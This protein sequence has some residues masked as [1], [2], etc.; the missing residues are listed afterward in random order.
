M[1]TPLHLLFDVQGDVALELGGDLVVRPERSDRRQ[2]AGD[3]S[4]RAS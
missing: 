4:E 3:P 2:Q 1:G